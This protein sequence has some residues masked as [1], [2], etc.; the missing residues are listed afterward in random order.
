MNTFYEHHQDSI[1]FAYRCFDRILLNDDGSVK[2]HFVLVDYLCRPRG[3]RL[4]AGSDVEAVT[5][6]DPNALTEW[7]VAEKV[8]VVVARALDVERGRQVT[9]R[10]IH[11]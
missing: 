1:R 5:L 4:Q 6:A 8:R 7:R 11:D 9:S 3:G 2:F 10:G